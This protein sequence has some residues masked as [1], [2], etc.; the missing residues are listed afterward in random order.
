[1]LSRVA[2]STAGR[3]SVTMARRG[4]LTYESLPESHQMLRDTCRSFANNELKPV[5]ADIDREH[6]FP[7]DQ[8]RVGPV[9]GAGAAARRRT[10]Q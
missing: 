4:F 6:R 1:M 9:Q 8:V 10:S 3:T 7:A 5:A 2:L